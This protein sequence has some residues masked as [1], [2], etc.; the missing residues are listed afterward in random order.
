MKTLQDLRPL[1][2]DNAVDF[3]DMWVHKHWDSKVVFTYQSCV[4]WITVCI[5]YGDVY[6]TAHRSYTLL[7]L[8]TKDSGGAETTFFGNLNHFV[9]IVAA[10]IAHRRNPRP[11][12][13]V[14]YDKWVNYEWVR[15]VERWLSYRYGIDPKL[16][17]M[18]GE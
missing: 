6:G 13:L 2:N 3:I 17:W 5:P 12:G 8:S 1:L 9:G 14:T 16:F 11:D 18:K 15:R 10:N 7:S 4:N